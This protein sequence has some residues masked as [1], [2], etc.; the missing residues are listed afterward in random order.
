MERF[1]LTIVAQ[2]PHSIWIALLVVAFL[3]MTVLAMFF[4]FCT[5]YRSVVRAHRDTDRRQTR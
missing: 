1:E 4:V 3:C 2:G 5:R